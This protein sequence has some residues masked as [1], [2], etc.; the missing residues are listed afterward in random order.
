[1]SD[2]CRCGLLFKR[3]KYSAD[4]YRGIYDAHDLQCDCGDA[5]QGVCVK[6]VDN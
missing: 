2:R 4:V 6:K 1:M 5:E 3:V